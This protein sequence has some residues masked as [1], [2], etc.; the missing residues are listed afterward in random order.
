VSL[1]KET[2]ISKIE[3]VNQWIIQVRT[4]TVVRENNIE[5]SRNIH[6]HTLLPFISN[7]EVKTENNKCVPNLDSNGK[8]QW[9]HIATDISN[10]DS[11][12]QAIANTTWTTKVKNAY[13]KFIE[14][15]EE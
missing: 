12:V 10:E 15:R 8:K 2:E 6:R 4:D 3:V 1:T 7:Y 11:S 9:T 5:I 13:K 14:S